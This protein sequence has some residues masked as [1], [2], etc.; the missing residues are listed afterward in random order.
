[1]TAAVTV[2]EGGILDLDAV[3]AVMEDSFDP[4]YGEAWTAA[5]C[6]GLMPMSGVWL[7]LARKDG[8]VVGFALGRIVLKEAELLLLAVKR[9]EQG[10]GIGQQ[11]LDRFSLVAAPS[12]FTWKYGT[13]IR[14]SNCTSS[15][16]FRRSA[17]AAT[18]IRAA[19]AR[20]TT[21]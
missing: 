15:M 12:G 3:M 19:T 18:I 20:F 11:L 9:Q 4:S 6:A 2:A 14:R 17:G 5:Q 8:D 13:E 16:A 21:H 10:Q 1:M 7:T